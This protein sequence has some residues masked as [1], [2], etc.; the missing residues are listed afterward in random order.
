[1]AKACHNVWVT[2]LK[3]PPI[4]FISLTY[5]M[6]FQ[7]AHTNIAFLYEV[8]FWIRLYWFVNDQL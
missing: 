1:M 4:T 3:L 2:I 7:G 6:N 8:G 5:A